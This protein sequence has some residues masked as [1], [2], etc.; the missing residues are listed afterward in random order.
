MSVHELHAY[1]KH[2]NQREIGRALG[3][4]ECCIHQFVQDSETILESGARVYSGEQRGVVYFLR[5]CGRIG[6][7]IPCHECIKDE[8]TRRGIYFPPGTT[9]AIDQAMQRTFNSLW[10]DKAYRLIPDY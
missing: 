1:D 7:Y 4:P 2:F 10:L 3:F 9:A 8:R 6:Y 5:E